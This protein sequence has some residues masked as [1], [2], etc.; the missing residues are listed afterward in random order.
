MAEMPPDPFIPGEL[1]TAMAA[2]Y[3]LYSSAVQ[4]GFSEAQSL[5]LVIGV[6]SAAMARSAPK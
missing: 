4:A 2:M 6:L 5:Q 1:G 3:D